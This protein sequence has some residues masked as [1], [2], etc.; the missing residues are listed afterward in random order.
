MSARVKCLWGG[1][2]SDAVVRHRLV[3]PVGYH[4]DGVRYVSPAA[5][6]RCAD[7]AE[8]EL[9]WARDINRMASEGQRHDQPGGDGSPI[10]PVEI[11]V[12]PVHPLPAIQPDVNHPFAISVEV[13][14]HH[15]AALGHTPSA[16]GDGYGAESSP[17][18]GSEESK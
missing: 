9:R 1:C 14:C 10:T 5:I 2:E 15:I 17:P 13:M 3:R 12:E 4:G 11:V 6:P 8:L 7:C 16:A 18:Q